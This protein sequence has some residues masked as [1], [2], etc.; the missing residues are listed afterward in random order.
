MEVRRSS[1][2]LVLIMILSAFNGL[3]QLGSTHA[4]GSDVSGFLSDDTTW[5]LENSPYIVVGSVIV[6]SGVTLTIEPGVEV[7]FDGDYGISVS[8][9]LRAIGNDNNRIN[10]TSNSENPTPEDWYRILVRSG[11]FAELSYADISYGWTG[12]QVFES[13]RGVVTHNTFFSNTYTV[14]IKS[15]SVVANNSFSYNEYGVYVTGTNNTISDNE[16]FMQGMDGVRL[17]TSSD[18]IVAG[19]NIVSTHYNGIKLRKSFNNV[20][21]DNFVISTSRGGIYLTESS[22]NMIVNNTVVKCGEGI[23]LHSSNHSVIFSNLLSNNG[24]GI[25]VLSSTNVTVVNNTAFSSRFQ[26]ISLIGSTANS[27]IFHNNIVDNGDQAVDEGTTNFWYDTYPSGGNYLSDYE[28]V[29]FNSTPSQDVPPPDGLGDTSYAIDWNSEA[30]YPLM[31]PWPFAPAYDDSGPSQPQN[32]MAFADVEQF[33]IIL[34]WDKNTEPDVVLYSIYLSKGEEGL[35]YTPFWDSGQRECSDT[36]CSY[37]DTWME[38]GQTYW[39]YIVAVDLMGNDSPIS[40]KANATMP[41]PETEPNDDTS[42]DPWIIIWLV[43]G[44]LIVIAAVLIVMLV[45]RKRQSK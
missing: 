23:F 3:I 45:R 27:Q 22:N 9:V 42:T 17:D 20:I 29:D 36:Q 33:Q 7:R 2:I 16:F 43:I 41:G 26:G 11:G 34:T 21:A 6:Q 39:Y 18:N 12:I 38:E 14:N 5:I 4:Q 44:A 31:N 10:I 30:M 28:G 8:G 24:H 13:G 19:N 25:E 35:Y 37:V 1:L 40:N 32:L 15:N